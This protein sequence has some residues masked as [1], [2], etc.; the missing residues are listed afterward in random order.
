MIEPRVYRAALVPAVLAV[1]L[2]MFSLESRPRPLPQGLAADVVFD[3]DQALTTLRSLDRAG[4]D[5]RPGTVGDRAA[6]AQMARGLRDRGFSV[7]RDR[8][9][10]ED[11]Q[12]VNVVGRRAGRSRREV[13]V[14]AAR[15][16]AGVPDA[17]VSGA[18]TAALL[19]IARVYA[20]RPSNKTVVLASVDGSGLGEEGTARLAGQLAGPEQVDAVLVLSGLGVPT[21]ERPEVVSWSGD[22]TRAGLGLQRTVVESLREE[23]GEVAG[24]AGPA[25][26]LARLAFPLGVG[27]QGVLLERGYDAVRISGD[28]ELPDGSGIEPERVDRE[29]LEGLGRATLRSL[30]ALDAGPRPEHGP[31]T[32]VT[33]VSQVVPGWVLSLL[34]LTLILP[35]LVAGVDA[36]ARARRRRLPVRSW[37]TWVGSG[38]V[39]LLLGVALVHVLAVTGAIP[40]PPAAP[41]DPA[42][43]PLDLAAGAVLAGI[44]LVVV[45]SWLGLRQLVLAADPRLADP[46]APGAAVAVVLVLSVTV[47]LLWLLNPFAALMCV[48]ALHLWLLGTLVDPL[49]PKRARVAML[50]GGLLLPVLLAFY[51]LAVLSLDPLAGAWYLLLLVA[52]GH[53]GT[54]TAL[55]GAALVSVLVSV[56]SIV[57][58]GSPPAPDP[59]KPAPP[60][61]RGPSSYAGPGSLGGTESALPRR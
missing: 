22:T 38:F 7:S 34:S 50:L 39:A 48:P 24:G 1:I 59:A 42:R 9:D 23:V 45:L 10:V 29:R 35:A 28:G 13:V 25:G 5:R 21:R 58:A 49:P 41:V 44:A 20:G 4:R 40:G 33:A 2:V 27:A 55:V 47:L 36:F 30:T 60:S 14:V 31:G 32:Y 3:G 51:Q 54:L 26:Q 61:V 11:K 52:G 16:A 46:E 12:L 56:V 6:G 57:R 37:L 8:F 53:V 15:D 18:D 17:G 19:E 43:F